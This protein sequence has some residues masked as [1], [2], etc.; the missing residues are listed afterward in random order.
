MIDTLIVLTRQRINYPRVIEAG[1]AL[2]AWRPIEIT[3]QDSAF[4][5]HKRCDDLLK[6]RV[7][8][9]RL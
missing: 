5:A 6:T 7:F 4:M 3:Q 9:F 2:V 1:K 8:P